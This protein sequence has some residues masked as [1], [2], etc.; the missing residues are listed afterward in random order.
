MFQQVLLGREKVAEETFFPSAFC[1]ADYEN[2]NLQIW[3]QEREESDSSQ[4]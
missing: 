2:G 4:R 1:N 3:C